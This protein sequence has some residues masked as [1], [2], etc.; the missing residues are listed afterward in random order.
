MI[1]DNPLLAPWT[2]PHG[3]PPFDRI[4]PEHFEPALRAAMDE[5]LAELHAVATQGAL[6]TFDNTV[7]AFDRSGRALGRITSV[8]YNLTA[9]Q[10]TPEL[11]A[12]QRRT[13][14]PLAAHDSAIYM[15]RALFERI[16]TLHAQRDTLAL[17]AEQRRLL[18]RRVPRRAVGAPRQG[19]QRP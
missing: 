6:P 15:N 12:V 3:L 1:T 16:D 10:T 7:A 4:R 2:A 19:A 11:Q 5:H 13:A 18:E 17:S 8:F 14:A 9:S